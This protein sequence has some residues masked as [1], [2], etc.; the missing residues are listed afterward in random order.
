VVARAIELN[1]ALSLPKGEVMR[2][3]SL[4][5]LLATCGATAV[6]LASPLV[7]LA[8]ENEAL[9]AVAK[10]QATL[11]NVWILIAAVLVIFTR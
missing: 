11:D 7:A 1:D 2:K 9:D 6:A 10:V 8:E 5:L 4:K 3:K